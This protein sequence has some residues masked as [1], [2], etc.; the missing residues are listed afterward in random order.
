MCGILSYFTDEYQDNRGIKAG[1]E[2]WCQEDLGSNP[3]S[4]TY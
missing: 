2:H 3:I 4:T 1:K